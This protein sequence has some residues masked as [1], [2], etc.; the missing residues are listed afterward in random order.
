MQVPGAP[1]PVG[2]SL[3]PC[4][5]LSLIP[6]RSAWSPPF[7]ESQCPHKGGESSSEGQH[8]VSLP[9]QSQLLAILLSFRR[10]PEWTRPLF[11]WPLVG[12]GTFQKQSAAPQILT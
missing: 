10:T 12:N 2:S 11:F 1:F 4:L 6:G 5:R 9:S 8:R 7:S 3:W